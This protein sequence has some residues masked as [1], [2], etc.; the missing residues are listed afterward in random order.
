MISFTGKIQ[1]GGGGSSRNFTVFSFTGSDSVGGGEG[2]GSSRNFP[3]SRLPDQI[4]WGGRGGVVAE[5]FRYLVYRIR[6]SG[7]GGVV[8]GIFHV[9]K[10][11]AFLGSGTFWVHFR[12]TGRSP[13]VY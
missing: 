13:A 3:L 6:F 12:A 10:S 5:I 11:I 7:G 8:A 2:R 1:W 9:N 4:Q